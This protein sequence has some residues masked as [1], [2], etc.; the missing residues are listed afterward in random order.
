MNDAQRVKKLIEDVKSFA[1]EGVD[2]PVRHDLRSTWQ[3]FKDWARPDKLDH[4]L[5][6]T[7]EKLKKRMPSKREA[8]GVIASTAAGYGGKEAA[9][10][11]G[12]HVA[13]ITVA[14]GLAATGIGLGIAAGMFILT[15][16]AVA[17]MAK[18]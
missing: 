17:G 12:A 16:A 13:T 11:L 8:L 3:T 2:P 10:A 5:R 6:V 4:G 15:R 7:G 9:I 18:Y 1:D 14:S